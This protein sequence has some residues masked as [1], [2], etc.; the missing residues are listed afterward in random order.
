MNIYLDNAATTP[1]DPRVLTAM[2]PYL[3]NNYGNASSLH[4]FGREAK[5]ALGSCR[6]RIAALLNAKPEE[7]VFT[8]GG[9][10]ADNVAIVS[11]VICNRIDHVITTAFEHPAV[12]QTLKSLSKQYHTRISFI[13]HDEKGNLD[14]RHLEYLLLTNTRNLVSVMHANN[15]IGNLNDIE[16]IGQLCEKYGALFHTDTVQ[17]MGHYSYN[18]SQLNVHFLA[19]SAH[20]FH[21]PKGVGFLYCRKEQQLNRIIHGGGQER[22][23]RA[24][25]EN[26]AGIV[27]MT[28]ALELAYENLDEDRSH[29]SGL[30]ATLINRLTGI[31]PDVRFNGNSANQDKSLY[32]I[33]SAGFPNTQTDLLHYLDAQGIAVA[34]GS[35]CSGGKPSAV[36]QALGTDPKM[37]TIRFSFSR[38]NTLEELDNVVEKLAAI[39]RLVAA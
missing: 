15:E 26:I 21:G 25:T 33:L 38:F 9:T 7:I 28:R 16:K 2:T 1:L 27:G 31:L 37:T 34:G 13:Q 18:L 11:A 5:A 12:L 10:E 14:L 3:I 39:Y 35:A 36:L 32:T 24:G 17:T 29:I 19:A 6:K 4:A 20:K 23:S 8:S 22:G 30:K